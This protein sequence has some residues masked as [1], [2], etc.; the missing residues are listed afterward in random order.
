MLMMSY[1]PC[2]NVRFLANIYFS[3]RQDIKNENLREF[4]LGN[5]RQFCAYGQ[6]I[7]NALNQFFRISN[8]Y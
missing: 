4:A 3:I 8:S 6:I 7:G 5:V 1:L 2:K